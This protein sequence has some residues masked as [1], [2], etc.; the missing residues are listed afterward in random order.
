[1]NPLPAL[2]RIL[3]GPA[4]LYG[5]L[6]LLVL[7]LLVVRRFSQDPAM[8]RRAV[9]VSG[10]LFLFV[11]LRVWLPLVP[12]VQRLV[13]GTA[14]EPARLVEVPSPL[15]H[16]LMVASLVVALLAALLLLALLLVDVLLVRRLG[17][18]VPKILPDVA[19]LTAFFF[20]VI[21]ILYYRTTLDITGL[22]TTSALFTV[23]IGLAL[24]DT[25][26]NL[27]SGLA[28]QTERS[29]RVGDWVR[30]GAH[31]GVVS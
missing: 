5:V 3:Q 31:E 23:V 4:V 10:L 15:A 27:F 17:V 21:L 28:L 25:L 13:E 9:L 1:M 24:Q 22:F 7:L 12:P 2:D 11:V 26:G 29:F 8:R 6:L 14:G 20:G 16:T 19:V 30:F 18:E